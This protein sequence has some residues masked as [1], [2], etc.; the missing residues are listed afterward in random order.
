MLLSIIYDYQIDIFQEPHHPV[1]KIILLKQCC[2]LYSQ[3]SNSNLKEYQ[4]FRK[5]IF[6]KFCPEFFSQPDKIREFERTFKS[7]YSP[8]G[9]CLPLINQELTVELILISVN[10]GFGVLLMLLTWLIV[11]QERTFY[12]KLLKIKSKKER[13]PSIRTNYKSSMTSTIQES[14]IFETQNVSKVPKDEKFS[15]SNES[16]TKDISEP[17]QFYRGY[18]LALDDE[19]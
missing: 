2:G 8:Q 1:W 17:K 15:T 9:A 10:L 13:K 18:R 19:T 6:S 5:T 12:L 11:W 14:T 7:K 4:W 3:Y 16:M